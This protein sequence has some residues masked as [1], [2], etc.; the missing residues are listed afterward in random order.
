M[1]FIFDILSRS[2]EEVTALIS[3]VIDGALSKSHSQLDTPNLFF[4]AIMYASAATIDDPGLKQGIHAYTDECFGRVLPMI[5]EAK[6]NQSLDGLFRSR[7]DFDRKLSELTIETPDKTPYNCLDMK[8]EVEERLR[9]YAVQ[10]DGGPGSLMGVQMENMRGHIISKERWMNFA[11][12]RYLVNNYHSEREGRFGFQKGAE[13]KG[14]EATFWQH[15]SHF[16]S[17]DTLSRA[18]GSEN[19]QGMGFS[20]KKS[21]EFS[22]FLARA[23]HIAG[24]IKMFLIACFPWLIFPVV[25]GYWRILAVWF[26]TY[27]SVLLWTPIWTLLYHVMLGVSL[28]ADTLHAFGQLDDGVSLYASELISSRMYNMFAI[29]S[30]LQILL[31]TLFT[32]MTVWFLSPMLSGGGRSQTPE[33]VSDSGQ[34]ISTGVKV[35]S[36]A[37][38]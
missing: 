15:L 10:K 7:P 33:F 38:L 19:L 36:V 6:E 37:A 20:L 11:M 3:R 14:G 35:A 23:P 17:F 16:F 22:E 26:F 18:L 1:S 27:F 9:A 4:K 21:E 2:A 32:G 8:R 28:S 30:W 31:G 13:F 5:K 29:Y 12:S 25:A 34:A 24:F